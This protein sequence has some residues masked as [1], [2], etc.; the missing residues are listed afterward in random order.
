[1]GTILWG[2]DTW[3]VIHVIADSSPDNFTAKE[4]EYYK[5]FYSS[6]AE[7]LPCPSCAVHYREF[8]KTDPPECN[9][10]VDLLKWTVRAHNNANKNT[11]KSELSYQEAFDKIESEIKA[12]EHGTVR[13]RISTTY[14][15]LMDMS[16]PVVSTAIVLVIILLIYR[17]IK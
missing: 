16:I 17:N 4:T 7:V 1:M 8:L 2:P 3:Y 14:E 10:R 11:G 13:G 9:N 15:K 5:Q 12:R 6:L